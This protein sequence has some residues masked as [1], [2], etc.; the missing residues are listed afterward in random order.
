MDATYPVNLFSFES[1]DLFYRCMNGMVNGRSI[2]I[3]VDQ[4][5]Q[6]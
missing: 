4:L 1:F 5:L 6:V 2:K 3:L